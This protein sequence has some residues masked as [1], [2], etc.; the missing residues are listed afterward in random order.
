MYITGIMLV[1]NAIL[2]GI[3][4]AVV[5]RQD[6][7]GDW[8]WQIFSGVVMTVALALIGIVLFWIGKTVLKRRRLRTTEPAKNDTEG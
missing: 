5:S 2:V 8:H 6:V 3:V 1:L 4:C 7:Q